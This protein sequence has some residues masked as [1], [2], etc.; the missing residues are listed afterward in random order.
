MNSSY[1]RR[2]FRALKREEEILWNY[3]VNIVLMELFTVMSFNNSK[4]TIL[5]C[6]SSRSLKILG[7]SRRVMDGNRDFIR[8]NNPF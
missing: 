5:L 3:S 4:R 8:V 6:I 7:V 1:C 2:H